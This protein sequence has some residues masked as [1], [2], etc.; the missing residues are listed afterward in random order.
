[1]KLN[2]AQRE[3][4]LNL[5]TGLMPHVPELLSAFQE[6]GDTDDPP[7]VGAQSYQF[8][9]SVRRLPCDMKPEDGSL[10]YAMP[11]PFEGAELE[12]IHY[13]YEPAPPTGFP[14]VL[15]VAAWRVPADVVL[16]MSVPPPA[17]P[18]QA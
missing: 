13:F 3:L 17:D 5:V 4:I 2:D 15:V 7:I 11:P 8:F 6:L 9:T 14:S 10:R 1:M 16:A 12:S 18:V